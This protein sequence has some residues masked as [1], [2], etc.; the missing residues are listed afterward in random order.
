[1]RGMP[2]VELP[3][4]V[5]PEVEVAVAPEVLAVVAGAALL[6][7]VPAGLAIPDAVFAFVV[8]EP[9]GTASP[10]AVMITFW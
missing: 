5:V 2:A 9:L 6:K 1:M 10:P 7:G 4:P 8:A 3:P